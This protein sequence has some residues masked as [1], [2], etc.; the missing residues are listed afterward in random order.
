MELSDNEKQY[1][2]YLFHL[3]DGDK[4]TK[5]GLNDA[6]FLRNAQLSDDKLGSIWNMA[7]GG[8]KGYLT[9]EEFYIALRL[10]AA[11]QAGS[12]ITREAAFKT[13]GASLCLL[14]S[15]P[16]F[17]SFRYKRNYIQ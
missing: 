11:L 13:P 6:A 4:D 7:D 2:S 3:A 8:Q 12:I 1:F 5:I 17:F 9:E 14:P 10:I 16:Y 15:C